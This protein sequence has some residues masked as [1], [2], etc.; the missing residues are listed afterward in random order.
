MLSQTL[1]NSTSNYAAF[2]SQSNLLL[3]Q[4]VKQNGTLIPPSSSAISASPVSATAVGS[5]GGYVLQAGQ[6]ITLSFSGK[7]LMANGR[8]VVTPVSGRTYG[9]EVVASELGAVRTNVT[10]G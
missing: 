10:A 6:S 5:S 1:Q 4:I 8:L 7:I 2:Q 3:F 9:I